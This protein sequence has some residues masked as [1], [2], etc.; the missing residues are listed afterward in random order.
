MCAAPSSSAGLPHR[1]K[2][3]FWRAEWRHNAK[4][5]HHGERVDL[6]PMLN[7]FPILDPVDRG[8][9][10]IELPPVAGYQQTLQD[11]DHEHAGADDLVT[12]RDLVQD[13]MLAWGGSPED[14][15]G[16]LQAG[17]PGGRPGIGGGWWFW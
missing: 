12:F 16:L 8:S 9:S 6:A 11:N 14:L 2:F 4:L 3:S 10:N 15:K 7:E 5:L 17:R 1:I 13:L